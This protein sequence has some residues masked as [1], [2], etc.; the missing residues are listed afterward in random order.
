MIW[1]P[2][3]CRQMPSTTSPGGSDLLPDGAIEP[4]VDVEVAEIGFPGNPDDGH[5]HVGDDR[6][7]NRAERAADDDADGEVDHVAAHRELAE[8]L[9][10]THGI[11]LVAS[12]GRPRGT[13]R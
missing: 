10:E 5:D 8:L 13:R 9:D 1:D 7:D 2:E 3:T 11:L 12:S 4:D 6:V